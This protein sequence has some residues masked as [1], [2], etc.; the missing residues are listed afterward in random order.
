MNYFLLL[1]ITA[2][3]YGSIGK[4]V[5]YD[6]DVSVIRGSKILDGKLGLKLEKKD[7]INT[8]QSSKVQIFFN[9]GTIVNMGEDAQFIVAEYMYDINRVSKTDFKFFKGG[10]RVVTGKIGKIAPKRFKLKTKNATIGIR[11]T[12]IVGNQRQIACTKGAIDVSSSGKTVVVPAGMITTTR[13]N[14]S[15]TKPIK[16]KESQLHVI[17]SGSE[18]NQQQS[19][20]YQE[21]QNTFSNRGNVRDVSIYSD[22]RDASNIATG[23]QNVNEQNIHSVVVEDGEV[24]YVYIR[25]KAQDVQS[26]SSGIRNSAKQN[27]G[28]INVD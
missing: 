13:K 27:I 5:K 10:F 8:F 25:G 12:I 1:I 2:S 28:T 17:D 3:L 16:Y 21:E 19:S 22:V 26:I 6:G 11:G 18:L 9:D 4:I 14:R 15:P 24:E 20:P 23:S 7:S